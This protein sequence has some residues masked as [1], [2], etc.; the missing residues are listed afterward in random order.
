MR[1][2]GPV[3]RDPLRVLT[4]VAAGRY[5]ASEFTEGPVRVMMNPSG[6]PIQVAQPIVLSE[7]PVFELDSVPGPDPQ[8]HQASGT[9]PDFWQARLRRLGSRLAVSEM[10]AL[11]ELIGP[12]PAPAIRVDW[13]AG[14]ERLGFTLPAD[15][16]EFIDTYEP[17]TLR[18]IRVTAPGAGGAWD[19]F[20]LLD[21]KYRQAR[22]LSR[23][24]GT[25][26]PYY[27]EPGGT[28]C[29]GETAEG[30]NCAWASAG[31][32]PEAWYAVVIPPTL[33]GFQTRAGISFSAMLAE[34]AARDPDSAQDLVPL[35]ES[36]A[37]PVTFTP[38][39][40]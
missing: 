2:L 15:Y 3:R 14:R 4:E 10:A 19:L 21:R 29:W 13:E 36:Y 25:D 24:P 8:G 9:R 11:R 7:R 16:R 12:P 39:P 32:D 28:V 22:D 23:N 37:G 5:D 20:A 6:P 40:S 33:R 31:P 17:R 1:P 27:P 35:P 34:H 18:N 26:P 38:R 30:W